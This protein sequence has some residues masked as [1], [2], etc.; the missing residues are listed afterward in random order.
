[1][2]VDESGQLTLNDDTFETL[3]P[4]KDKKTSRVWNFL[5]SPEI[6]K[7]PRPEWIIQ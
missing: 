3:A 1:M 7:Q 5:S 2:E 6:V 4:K